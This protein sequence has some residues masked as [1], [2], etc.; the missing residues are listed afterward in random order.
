MVL[1]DDDA[2]V[3]E[4]DVEVLLFDLFVDDVDS[5]GGMKF[6]VVL[7][8]SIISDVSLMFRYLMKK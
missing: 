2:G 8:R 4:L 5:E 6:F 3:S 1:S 7:R